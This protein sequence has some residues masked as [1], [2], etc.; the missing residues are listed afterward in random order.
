MPPDKIFINSCSGYYLG[1]PG[2]LITAYDIVHI[3]PSNMKII[4]VFVRVSAAA[5][6]EFD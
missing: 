1:I 3:N 5:S 6:E 4:F 2:L